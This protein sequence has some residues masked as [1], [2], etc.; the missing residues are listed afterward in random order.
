MI[1]PLEVMVVLS[2]LIW[3]LAIWGI[4]SKADDE[5]VADDIEQERAGDEGPTREGALRREW[6]EG[7]GPPGTPT[8][9]DGMMVISGDVDKMVD[10]L[11]AR[12]GCRPQR[13]G[14]KGMK[15]SEAGQASVH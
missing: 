3:A 12:Y 8:L 14:M 2:L 11:E 4:N 9:V 7:N 6:W 15:G 13:E 10:Y 1:N 5:R